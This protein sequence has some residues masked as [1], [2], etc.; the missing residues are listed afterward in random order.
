MEVVGDDD[1]KLTINDLQNMQYVEMCVKECLRYY[2]PVP[3]IARR[4]HE[5]MLVGKENTTGKILT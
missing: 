1:R 4:L 5:D 3:L 2:P